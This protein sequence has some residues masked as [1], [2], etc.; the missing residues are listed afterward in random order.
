MTTMQEQQNRQ[1]QL[2]KEH[3]ADL[4]KLS[5][6][7]KADLEKWQAI[8]R[9][10]LRDKRTLPDSRKPSGCSSWR[11]RTEDIWNWS[12]SSRIW[13]QILQHDV[14]SIKD[15]LQSRIS[16]AEE[17]LENLLATQQKL[18]SELH[19]A[20]TGIV[21]DLMGELEERFATKTQ[22]ATEMSKAKAAHTL[23]VSAPEFI[24]SHESPTT[25]SLAGGRA[26]TAHFQK[27]PPFDGRSPWGAYKL[28]FE[29]LADVNGWSDAERATYLAVSLR[30]SALTVLSNIS[31]DHRGEYSALVNALDKRFGSAHQAVLNRAKLKERM[32]KR[33]ESL[34]ELA[35]SVERL[36]R[37]AYPDASTEMIEIL[38]KD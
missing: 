34:P 35:E 36:T 16:S 15:V 26:A 9:N 32:R 27:P 33:E 19:A 5:R 30:G 4:E 13:N 14:S 10:K 22:L 24:P 17:G 28:Q 8:S 37:L 1:E 7:H 20:K 2:S 23:R 18:T 29:M 25:E 6:D 21:N 31:P 12:I 38:S 11:S 3:K